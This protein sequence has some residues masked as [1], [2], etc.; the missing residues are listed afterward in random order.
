MSSEIDFKSSLDFSIILVVNVEMKETS[1]LRAL[2]GFDIFP[3]RPFNL[4]PFPLD[5][6]SLSG[7]TYPHF[8]H[9]GTPEDGRTAVT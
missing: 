4:S 2:C 6:T 8:F 9:Q 1:P 7:A 3:A 5:S